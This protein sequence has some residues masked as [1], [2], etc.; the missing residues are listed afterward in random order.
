M[1]NIVDDIKNR[2]DIVQVISQYVQ[3]K[4]AGRNY[5][6]LSPF[7][8][9]KTPSFVVSPEKQIFHCFSSGKGGDIFTF[10]QEFEGVSFPEALQI[11]ADQAGIKVANID[12]YY[13]K[14]PKSE[15]D[16]YFKAHELACEF[17]ENQLWD[18]S[19]G[20]K[21]LDYLSKR[22]VTEA[23]IKEFRVGFAPDAFDALYPYLLKKGIPKKI[24][25]N[26]GFASSKGIGEDEI[27][28]KFRSR[29]M[30]P[31]IDYMGKICGFGGRALKTDQEPK[32]LNSPENPIYNK[33]KVLYG[34]YQSKQSIKEKDQVVFVE[35]YFDV[36]LPHQDGVK[37]VVATSGTAL[38]SDQI[39][40]IKRLTNNAVTCFDTD[41]AGFEATKRSYFLFNEQGINIKTLADIGVKDPADFVKENPGKFIEALAK[42]RDFLLFYIEKL[43][44]EN[45]T[46]VFEGRSAVLS[47]ILPIMKVM[48]PATKDFYIREFA[49]KL[50]IGE[51]VFYD[52]INSFALPKNH[53]AREVDAPSSGYKISTE[54]I[55]L[56]L[57]I[58][59]PFLFIQTEGLIDENSFKETEK[60]IYKK[61]AN[62]Y[63]SHRTNLGEWDF[64]G[65]SAEEKE[66][67]NVLSLYAEDNYDRFGE[68]IKELEIKQLT[69]LLK[70]ERKLRR[71]SEVLDEISKAEKEGDKERLVKFLKE[72]QELISN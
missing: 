16:E 47:E 39:R 35:G 36:I 61:L 71:L 7:N 41:H 30:F 13:K 26:S 72:Q 4:K 67:V 25:L 63:N 62:Q 44:N 6:G 65:F 23:T 60:S 15:K 43:A 8:A 58:R 10:I 5:K 51:R 45:D 56:S 55:I 21:V 52:E 66:K 31:I 57:I 33:S 22:G 29:L 69:D 68:E 28:D 17:F 9:E 14:E 37:N 53:P 59:Y 24:L 2:L 1:A 70:K 38:T 27:Y 48:A 18:T 12:K 19:E 40:L 32:Y 11:L 49:S 54:E 20:K 3:L 64:D 42:A 34:L 46:S 50:K